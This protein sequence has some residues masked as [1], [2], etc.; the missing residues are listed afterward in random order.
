MGVA[1]GTGVFVA[2]AF[3]AVRLNSRD[4]VSASATPVTVRLFFSWKRLTAL[5]VLLP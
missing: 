1:A 2:L 4:W 3:R 5:N